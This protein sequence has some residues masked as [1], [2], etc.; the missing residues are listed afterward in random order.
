MLLDNHKQIMIN[1]AE[2]E[3]TTVTNIMNE[4]I[5]VFISTK[6][7]SDYTELHMHH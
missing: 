1:R 2:H 6:E 7:Y 3:T 5:Q 4:I